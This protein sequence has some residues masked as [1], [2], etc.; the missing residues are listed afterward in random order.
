MTITEPVLTALYLVL[1]LIAIIPVYAF[2]VGIAWRIAE[3]F[4]F[5]GLLQ[6]DE[7]AIVLL[8]PIT[9]FI[10]GM[11][12]LAHRAWKLGARK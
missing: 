10:F 7:T 2:T 1:T 9:G 8:W 11:F 12:W 5:E 6:D 4:V 3:R